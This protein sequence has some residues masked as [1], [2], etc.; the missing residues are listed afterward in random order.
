MSPET[1]NEMP[2]FPTIDDLKN[3]TVL[4]RADW[5]RMQAQLRTGAMLEAERKR[6]IAEK[7]CLHDQSMEQVGHWSNTIKVGC[8][9]E[10]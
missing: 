7:Q 5:D 8:T 9:R 2:I 4:P 1:K 3:V 6:R 10:P